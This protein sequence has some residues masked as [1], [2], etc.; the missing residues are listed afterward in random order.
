ML[1]GAQVRM[2]RAALG[3]GVRDLADKAGTTPGTI[4]R[5]ENG[6]DALGG[7]LTK[8][9]DA[10]TSAGVVFLADGE[11][12]SGGPGVRLRGDAK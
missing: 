3:W 1:S 12:V 7:T 10:L 6:A 5:I 4:S 2:A 11:M 8:I 9:E